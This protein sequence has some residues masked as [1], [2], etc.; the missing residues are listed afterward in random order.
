MIKQTAFSSFGNYDD[1]D[2]DDDYA[3]VKDYAEILT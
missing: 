2:D 3:K 1:V